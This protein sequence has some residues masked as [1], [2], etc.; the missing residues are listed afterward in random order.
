MLQERPRGTCRRSGMHLN[1]S[2]RPP[3]QTP[4]QSGHDAAND[5]TVS[6][7]SSAVRRRGRLAKADDPHGCEQ[8]E[9]QRAT[10]HQRVAEGRRRADHR[11]T[12]VCSRRCDLAGV[13]G[14]VVG[15][16]VGVAIAGAVVVRRTIGVAGV[17]A[18]RVAIVRPA[19]VAVVVAVIVTIV[20]AVPGGCRA[21]HV[22]RVRLTSLGA[23]ET[24]VEVD[25]A[26]LVHRNGQ[27]QRLFS[28]AEELQRRVGL[29]CAL[30]RNDDRQR[31]L[32]VV[33]LDRHHGV[34]RGR[35]VLGE[36]AV[37]I[38]TDDRS[39]GLRVDRCFPGERPG[40][41]VDRRVTRGARTDHERPAVRNLNGAG[42]RLAAAG[43]EVLDTFGGRDGDVLA[44][45]RG[46]RSR[47]GLRRDLAGLDRERAGTSRLRAVVVEDVV[48]VAVL[49]GAGAELRVAG[50]RLTIHEDGVDALV[51]GEVV[52][53][54]DEHR[55][56]TLRV[57]V[58]RVERHR[59]GELGPIFCVRGS[60]TRK[61]ESHRSGEHS[62]LGG[63]PRH[64]E[65]LH[66]GPSCCS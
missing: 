20:I 33:V 7:P 58:H 57:A 48:G 24:N 28:V 55:Q 6:G 25:I 66:I 41:T 62:Q 51:V 56:V 52:G 5:E 10:A 22:D 36:K 17:R 4:D 38:S 18:V 12:G 50:K 49:T 32:R 46:R 30:V 27:A 26:A 45:L 8:H 39:H 54:P 14:P 29:D 43:V 19:G 1:Q 40:S 63:C 34:H 3:R 64:V 2:A 44:G 13:L 23:R 59:R 21:R 37:Q 53:R 65:P 61:E 15:R 47:D 60:A 31:T 11:V 16:P 9:Q 42:Q 35:V